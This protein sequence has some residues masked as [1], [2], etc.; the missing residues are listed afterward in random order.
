MCIFLTGEGREANGCTRGIFIQFIFCC[1][2][3]LLDMDF[4]IIF[5]ALFIPFVCVCFFAWIFFRLLF[6]YYSP[7]SL[8]NTFCFSKCTMIFCAEQLSKRFSSFKLS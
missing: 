7:I 6:C 1:M 4:V 5:Q 8:L 2:D 3:F